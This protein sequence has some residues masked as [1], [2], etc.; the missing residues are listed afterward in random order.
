M[1]TPLSTHTNWLLGQAD[2]SSRD[3]PMLGCMPKLF[4]LC[5]ASIPTRLQQNPTHPHAHCPPTIQ[6]TLCCL[7]SMPA[8]AVARHYSAIYHCLARTASLSIPHLPRF[9]SPFPWTSFP[10]PFES[11]S[12]QLPMEGAF[13]PSDGWDPISIS[14]RAAALPAQLQAAC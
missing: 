9:R 13:S 8:L 12:F 3:F 1:P 11:G 2:S 10:P 14:M 5:D 7:H 6:G 4:S